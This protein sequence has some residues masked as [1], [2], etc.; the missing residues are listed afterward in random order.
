MQKLAETKPVG[1]AA[2][3]DGGGGGERGSVFSIK[4]GQLINQ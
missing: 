1:S 4:G 2:V 3:V